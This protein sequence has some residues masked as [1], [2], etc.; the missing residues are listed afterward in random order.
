MARI[1]R[2]R[3]DIGVEEVQRAIKASSDG[4]FRIRLMVVQK[5]L[6]CNLSMQTIAKELIVNR[7]TVSK[8]LKLFNEGG[9]EGL[10]PKPAGRK[11]GNPKYHDDIFVEIVSLLKLQKRQWS[12]YQI[13][14]HIRKMHGIDIPESTIYYR[15]SK[16][17]HPKRI[18]NELRK[19]QQKVS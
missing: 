14:R 5:L 1:A 18:S 19:A 13:K 2:I 11:E 9:I 15:L 8:C 6:S 7:E 3:K 4:T 16:M 17:G 12:V 10:K